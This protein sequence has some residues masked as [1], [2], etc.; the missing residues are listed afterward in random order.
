MFVIFLPERGSY[1]G[2]FLSLLNKHIFSTGI[3]KKNLS[4]KKNF[5]SPTV[6]HHAH[7][8][9]SP[10]LFFL[11]GY[12]YTIVKRKDADIYDSGVVI[13]PFSSPQA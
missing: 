4:I 2:F 12:R 1:V 5:K 8:V 3:L 6:N 11:R 10:S 13:S 7:L 9:F